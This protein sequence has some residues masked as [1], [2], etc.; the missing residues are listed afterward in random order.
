MSN[1]GGILVSS[2]SVVVAPWDWAVVLHVETYPTSSPEGCLVGGC[3]CSGCWL[4]GGR[5]GVW[6]GRVRKRHGVSL[7]ERVLGIVSP[8][9]WSRWSVTGGHATG[10]TLFSNTFVGMWFW[11]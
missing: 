4:L 6:A 10:P 9:V 5:A 3:F 1:Y 8:F 7:G 11:V 2:P